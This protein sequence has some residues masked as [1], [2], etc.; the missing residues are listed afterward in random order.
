MAY[1]NLESVAEGITHFKSSWLMAWN[2]K[3][4]ILSY[5]YYNIISSTNLDPV[6]H[7]WHKPSNPYN[8][9]QSQVFAIIASSLLIFFLDEIRT[10][11]LIG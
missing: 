8:N 11:F 3:Q 4:I 5:L 2:Y 6:F 7:L 9:S 10:R 1:M